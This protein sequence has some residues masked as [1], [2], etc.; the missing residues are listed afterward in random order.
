VTVSI[1]FSA[2]PKPGISK[3]WASWNRP[4]SAERNRRDR[5][6]GLERRGEMIFAVFRE[7]DLQR[8]GI[9][10]SRMQRYDLSPS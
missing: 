2:L 6:L 10:R 4:H 3:R 1:A 8:L 9:V 5:R 7:G